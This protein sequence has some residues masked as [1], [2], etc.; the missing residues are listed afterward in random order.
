[1]LRHELEELVSKLGKVMGT[2]LAPHAG[3]FILIITAPPDPG[4]DTKASGGQWRVASS[5][6]MK[7]EEAR[8]CLE[9]GIRR[10]Q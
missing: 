5:S 4:A 1:M 9:A 3:E 6:N 7:P 8:R 2:Q 10:L